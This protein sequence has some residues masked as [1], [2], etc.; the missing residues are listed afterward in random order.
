MNDLDPRILERFR[1]WKASPLLFVTEC[2]QVVPSD[3]QAEALVSFANNKRTTIRSGHG[4]GKST[5]ASWLIMWFLCTRPYAKVACTAPTARQLSDILW[6]E[7]SKWMRKSVVAD[8]FVIQKDKIFHKDAPKEW[9]CRAISPSVKAGADEQAETL[10]GLHGDHLL[11]VCDE[12]SGIPDPVFIPLEGALTQEDNKV[13]LIGNPTKNKGYF[14]ETHFDPRV[15]NQWNKLHWDSRKSSNVTQEMTNYFANKY[16]LDSNVFRIRVAGEPPLEDEKTLISLSWAQQCIDSG[17]VCD[18][19]D[20]LYLGVDVAR[21]GDDASVILPRQGGVIYPWDTFRGLN[22]ISLGGH[23][24]QEFFEQNAAGIAMDE[25]GV[26]AGVTDWLHKNGHQRTCFGVNVSTASS[27]PKKYHR[28]RD[29]LWWRVREKCLKGVYNFP[30]TKI[31][32]EGGV[33]LILG[34]ELANELS[35]P[36]YDHDNNGAIIV[37]SKRDMKKRGV[38]SPNIAD[39]LCLTEYFEA[40]AMNVWGTQKAKNKNRNAARRPGDSGGSSDPNAWMAN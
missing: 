34:E 23:I 2:I 20:P 28:L 6:S 26:G 9:W 14:Y 8:D 19:D 5:T 11:I 25:I 40:I 3:Q 22:T 27:N 36:L 13:L 21:F 29:E 1:R 18:P 7:L 12:A 31:K 39:A 32:G 35:S 33:D 37:E 24:N 17:V 15:R 4:C 10:A 38:M 16:G 30:A